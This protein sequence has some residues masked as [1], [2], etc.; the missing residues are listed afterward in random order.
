MLTSMFYFNHYK[1]YLV[2]EDSPTTSAGFSPKLTLFKN[3]SYENKTV[4]LN[5]AYRGDIVEYAGNISKKVVA[6][7]DASRLVVQDME[8]FEMNT[9]NAGSVRE[10]EVLSAHISQFTESYNTA[11]SFALSQEHSAK[12]RNFAA[13]QSY[14]V[15]QNQDV[16]KILGV[17]I[18]KNGSLSCDETKI[19]DMSISKLRDAVN[20]TAP[21]FE[22]LYENAK[23]LLTFPLSSH[24][25]FK[26]LRYYYNYK[27]GTMQDDTFKIIKSG[28]L[29]DIA[30]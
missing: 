25:N 19:K 20:K 22:S 4:L 8:N 2:K 13:E 6:F 14:F 26:G 21:V 30:V 3:N 1:P 23:Q 5:T 24:M 15:T 12:L 16:L 11:V 29:V 10:R 7:K 27:L 9:R 17:K 28:I 18:D